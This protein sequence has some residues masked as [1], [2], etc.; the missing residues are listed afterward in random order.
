MTDRIGITTL[1]TAGCVCWATSDD[2]VFQ[3][4]IEE[5]QR[6]FTGIAVAGK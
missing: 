4:T 5:F 2:G 3:M 1:L 6:N